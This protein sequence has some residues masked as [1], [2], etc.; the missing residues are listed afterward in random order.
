MHPV[1][2]LLLRFEGKPLLTLNWE[3]KPCWV[4]RHIAACI[5]YGQ[6]GKRLPNKILH[7]WADEFLPGNDYVLLE[8]AALEVLHELVAEAGLPT[9]GLGR[10]SLL[11]LF[12]SGLHLV[13][14]KTS[15]PIGRRL[16]RFLADQ[17]LPQLARTGAYQ[18]ERAEGHGQAEA[19]ASRTA[20]PARGP[21]T[22]AQDG[23]HEVDPE[24]PTLRGPRTWQLHPRGPA[25][26]RLA[27]SGA[28]LRDPADPPPHRAA[29][30]AD[31]AEL[32]PRGA[33]GR[34]GAFADPSAESEG[35]DDESIDPRI[36]LD[37]GPLPDP[38][39]WAV[40]QLALGLGLESL[41]PTTAERRE[42]RLLLQ[43]RTRARWV[44][45]CDRRMRGAAI[46]RLIDALGPILSGASRSLLEVMAAEEATG[47][48]L[49]DL[50][51]PVGVA[52][53][54]SAPEAA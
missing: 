31:H 19:R 11:L 40:R 45:H 52:A 10:G 30:V 6:A 27:P 8:G 7:E 21:S 49:A 35:L 41:R 43:A 12:E 4:A 53:L 34:A 9:A 33:P 46:A 5:G 50:V 47:V 51:L 23:V 13:L 20:P 15:Q 37:D 48:E 39:L 26:G 1:S 22:S 54:P 17:V 3:G 29:G 2:P 44:D 18:P 36:G 24:G 38:H 42:D 32:P 14:A 25:G 28:P 16:R